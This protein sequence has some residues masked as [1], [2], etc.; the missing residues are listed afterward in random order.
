MGLW[1]KFLLTVFAGASLG[2]LPAGTAVAADKSEPTNPTASVKRQ[3]ASAQY[4][5]AEEQRAALNSKPSDKR[6]L[7]DY[8][9]VVTSYRPSALDESTSNPRRISMNPWCVN[10]PP[11]SIARTHCCGQQSCS[12][13]TWRT[14]RKRE[15]HMRIF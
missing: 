14:P 15:R 7:A 2:F 4:A 5:R 6:T 11:A 1:K 12:A 9:Q 13:I 3:S 10:I 8:K